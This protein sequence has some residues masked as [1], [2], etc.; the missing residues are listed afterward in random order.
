MLPHPLFQTVKN[1]HVK[2]AVIARGVAPHPRVASLALRAIHLLA[3][4]SP[5]PDGFGRTT[6]K[7]VTFGDT[8]CHVAWRLLAMTPLYYTL[9]QGTLL[10]P[11]FFLWRVGAVL[12]V[13]PTR[14]KFMI[15]PEVTPQFFIF[16]FSFFIKNG[17]TASAVRPFVI[18]TSP[19]RREKS[20]KE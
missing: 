12:A 2:K 6:T 3:I 1:L 15:R 5:K 4:R 20:K 7:M 11:L 13:A 19:G 9:E 16:H 18:R 8:D 14:S 17:P 10:R